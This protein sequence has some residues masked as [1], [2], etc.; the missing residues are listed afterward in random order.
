MTP[1]E[2]A[3]QARHLLSNETL[4]KAFVDIR[5]GLVTQLE[6]TPFHEVDTQHEIA[7]MLKLLN[8]LKTQLKA[9]IDADAIERDRV[10]QQT[11]IEKMRERLT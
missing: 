5:E 10:K 8:K 4:Q 1:F 6:S 7:L 9:Y 2:R 11:F 3:E